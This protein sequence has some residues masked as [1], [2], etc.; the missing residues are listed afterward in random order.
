MVNFSYIIQSTTYS[1]SLFIEKWRMF[2]NKKL[3][4][5][6]IK[7]ISY[8]GDPFY[9]LK[10][11]KNCGELTE[12]KNNTKEIVNFILKHYEHGGFICF[13]F[14]MGVEDQSPTIFSLNM[15]NLVVTKL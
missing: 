5:T 6:Y 2:F 8:I 14:Y 10:M 13:S 15:E 3:I 11:Y 9:T 1:I 4:R 12:V 7:D